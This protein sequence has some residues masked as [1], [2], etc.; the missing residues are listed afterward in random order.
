M[1]V[2]VL[3]DGLPDRPGGRQPGKS[4]TRPWTTPAPTAPPA[5]AGP[6]PPADLEIAIPAY[7]EASRLPQ[8]LRRT[9]QFLQDQAWSSRVVVVDNGSCDETADIARAIADTTDGSVPSDVVGCARP[10]KGAVVRRA[11][12]TSRSR[13]VGFFDADLA[14]PVET[15]ATAMTHLTRGAPAVIGSRHVPG[16]LTVHAQPPARRLGGA[17]FR[18]LTRSMV[19]GIR[20]TQCGFKFFNR[21]AV[22]H[23]LV[24]CRHTGF[25]FDV[26]LLR[27]LQ[28][29]RLQIVEIPV[30][31][32]DA[33]SSTFHPLR[34]GLPSFGAVLQMRR[35][36]PGWPA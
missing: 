24:A 7:N 12:L 31:W 9:A 27:Q 15:L 32:S 19:K 4:Q 29:S 18:L 26:E 6:R 13:Y 30:A 8:T 5:G 1:N 23:A 25:A 11:L 36:T 16:A 17:A 20:D 22:T 14:T 21:E 3:E 33:A 34:D 10:G 2:V 28:R 35:A